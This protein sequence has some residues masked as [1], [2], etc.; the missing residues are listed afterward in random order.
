MSEYGYGT[1]QF[2]DL[3]RIWLADMAA[4]ERYLHR[5]FRDCGPELPGVKA[6]LKPKPPD[7]ATS[8]E[9]S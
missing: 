9:E 4:L 6:K 3:A 2:D 1:N 5:C 7:T 8:V